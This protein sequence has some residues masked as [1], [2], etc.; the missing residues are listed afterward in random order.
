MA[1]ILLASAMATLAAPADPYA[2]YAPAPYA[3]PAPAPYHAPAPAPYHPPAK[4]HY[5]SNYFQKYIFMHV[6]N[7]H[8]LLSLINNMIF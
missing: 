3:P 6:S 8:V 1:L 7:M 5:V 4:P 2:P